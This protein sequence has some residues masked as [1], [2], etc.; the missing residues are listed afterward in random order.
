MVILGG[1][2]FLMSEVPLYTQ[3]LV[4]MPASGTAVF[5]H[6]VPCRYY[7]VALVLYDGIY[8]QMPTMKP[9]PRPISLP[10]NHSQKKNEPQRPTLRCSKAGNSHRESYNPNPST[11]PARTPHPNPYNPSCCRGGSQQ[12][13]NFEKLHTRYTLHATRCNLHPAPNTLDTRQ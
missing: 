3:H 7:M 13:S 12:F 10:N 2:V 6:T 11:P 5:P 4:W 8:V 9:I 1:W